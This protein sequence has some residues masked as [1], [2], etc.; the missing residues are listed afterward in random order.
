MSKYTDYEG[1]TYQIEPVNGGKLALVVETKFDKTT[2]DL[3]PGVA[4]QVCQALEAAY[5]SGK[6]IEKE[7]LRLLLGLGC[8]G[9]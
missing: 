7:R 1:T 8:N 4:R 3:Y 5:I 2:H 6:R 9:D